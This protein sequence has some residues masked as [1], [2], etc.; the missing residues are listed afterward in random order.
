M[1][2]LSAA[3]T[4]DT[5]LEDK[6]MRDSM[7]DRLDVLDKVKK[8][9]LIPG[10]EM[11]TMRQIADFYEVEYRAIQ[12]CYQR[13]RE[14]IDSDGVSIMTSS[15]FK[16]R[17]FVS[18]KQKQMGKV[19]FDD[20]YGNELVLNPGRSTFFSKRAILRIGMLLRDSAVAQEVRSQL[21]N[22]FA[23]STVPQRVESL[24]EET[25]LV[26][27]VVN[28]SDKMEIALALGE[29]K[30]Y[31]ERFQRELEAA[32]ADLTRRN[33]ALDAENDAISRKV[34]LWSDRAI[35]EKLMRVYAGKRYVNIPFAQ[36][37]KLAWSAFY[38]ELYLGYRISLA[39]RR[40]KDDYCM[41]KCLDYLRDDEW[42]IAV[43]VA[44][45][46]CRRKNYDVLAAIGNDVVFE[47]IL[48]C[49]ETVPKE[50]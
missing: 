14:E 5:M 32:N 23:K 8:L 10:L 48:E 42:P 44:Y 35:L 6:E 4:A 41:K 7:A 27:S 3:H 16:M 43:K 1:T 49:D 17:H 38:D 36:K 24:D 29:Y 22:T 50:G 19:V 46:M 28:G 12:K 33:E 34:M 45:G 20:G 47:R 25:A 37:A 26:M 40:K 2:M 9:F 15:D 39:L 30:R 21:L 18:P 13:S 31:K 11:M